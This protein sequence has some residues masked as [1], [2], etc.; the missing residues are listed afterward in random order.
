MTQILFSERRRN[1]LLFGIKLFEVYGFLKFSIIEVVAT[2]VSVFLIANFNFDFTFLITLR[3]LPLCLLLLLLP[4][5]CLLLLLL[6]HLFLFL[7]EQLLQLLVIRV[8]TTTSS[9]CEHFSV[10]EL[11][12]IDGFK[13]AQVTQERVQVVETLHTNVTTVGRHLYYT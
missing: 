3:P 12:L 6:Y 11:L 7:R 1:G 8:S 5:I 13:L 9:V 2:L 10:R 4:Y